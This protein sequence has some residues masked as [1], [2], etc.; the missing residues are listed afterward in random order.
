MYICKCGKE[1]NNP[2]SFNGHKG[3]CKEHQLAKYGDLTRYNTRL[4]AFEKCAHETKSKNFKQRKQQLLADWL[5]SAPV[6]ET[7]GIVM[8]S[9]Y[10]SGRFCSRACA[11]SRSHS[12]ETRAKIADSLLQKGYVWLEDLSGLIK[13]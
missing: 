1:F 13:P 8:T 4:T 12:A 10:G 2:Q 6:C 11:N 3:H 9:K 5:A 7:C